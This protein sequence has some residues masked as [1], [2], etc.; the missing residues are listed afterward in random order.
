MVI[1]LLHHTITWIRNKIMLFKQIILGL[2]IIFISASCVATDKGKTLGR[3]QYKIA[4]ELIQL[5]KKI[6]ITPLE[7]PI[8][9]GDEFESEYKQL[10]VLSKEVFKWYD[11]KDLNIETE[12]LELKNKIT[13][14]SKLPILQIK[15]L[16]EKRAVVRVGKI[17][18]FLNAS[19]ATFFLVK[20]D[21]KWIVV[22]RVTWVS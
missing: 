14:I 19:G 17:K 12:K 20:H 6:G 22:Y 13:A 16:S 21:S 4:F 2:C 15:T 10:N 18:G 11:E 5:Y 1:L 3:K 8:Q 9:I 7:V